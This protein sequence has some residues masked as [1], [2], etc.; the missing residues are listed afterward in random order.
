MAGQTRFAI[1]IDRNVE[2]AF[3]QVAREI[4]NEKFSAAVPTRWNFDKWGADQSNVHGG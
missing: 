2:P 1:S 3:V 4:P